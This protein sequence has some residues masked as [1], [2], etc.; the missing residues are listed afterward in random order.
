MNCDRCESELEG[1]D[2]YL[3]DDGETVCGVCKE[4]ELSE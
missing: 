4:M 3:T 2:G 1:T